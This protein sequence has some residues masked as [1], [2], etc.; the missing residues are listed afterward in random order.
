MEM[1]QSFNIDKEAMCLYAVTDRSWLNGRALEEQVEAALKGGITCLQLREKDLD[2]ES[3]IREAMRIKTLAMAYGVPFIIN[4]SVKVAL[5]VD[6]D[7]VHVGQS[8]MAAQDVRGMIGKDKILGV[9]VQTVEQAIKAK[10]AGA[11]Y[12]GVGAMF[13]TSTKKDANA[14]SSETLKAIRQSVDL[15]IVAIGGINKDNVMKLTGCGADGIAVVSAIFA[16]ENIEE[17]TKELKV[18]SEAMIHK[19]VVKGVIF[20]MDGTLLDSMPTW[21]GIGAKLLANNGIMPPED[22]EERLKELSFIDTAN[23]F[24]ND[25]GL[26]MSEEEVVAGINDLMRQAYAEYIP[27]KTGAKQL[28]ESLKNKGYKMGVATATDKELALLG[29]KRLEILD[30]FDVVV[31]CGDIGHWKDEPMIYKE[32]TKMMGLEEAEVVIVEDAGYCVKTAKE[33]GF[34]VVGVYDA[35]A[36]LETEMIKALSDHYMLDLT[37]MEAWLCKK[38]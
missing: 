34:K 16:Q 23:Y 10:E 4:D 11:D 1:K 2:E 36:E 7:G 21:K 18:L 14:T 37:E 32:T 17:A 38:C 12:I 13:T 26:Q 29:L 27:L 35:A 9:S 5:A 22:I 28:L 6:A 25:L 30:Y 31:S 33:A 24:I 3:F 8:D 20:D 19:N 15:P